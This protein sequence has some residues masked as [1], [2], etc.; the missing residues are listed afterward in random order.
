MEFWVKCYKK[1]GTPKIDFVFMQD[2]VSSS[3]T[4]KTI[5]F[6]NTKCQAVIEL[7]DWPSCSSDLNLID[8]FL[9][10]TLEEKFYYGQVHWED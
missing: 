2:G 3:Y 8:Y 4:K 6:L 7:N 1:K 9:G 10:F 5:A